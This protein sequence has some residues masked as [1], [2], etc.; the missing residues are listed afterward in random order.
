MFSYTYQVL[1]V[2][3]LLAKSHGKYKHSISITI[4]SKNTV[5]QKNQDTK[6]FARNFAKG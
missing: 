1:V 6:T 5:S 2:F 4:V 3:Y